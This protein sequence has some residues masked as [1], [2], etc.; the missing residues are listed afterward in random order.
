MTPQRSQYPRTDQSFRPTLSQGKGV[1]LLVCDYNPSKASYSI[2]IPVS[3]LWLPRSFMQCVL[4][5]SFRVRFD[6][7]RADQNTT[8]TAD[9]GAPDWVKKGPRKAGQNS[10]LAAAVSDDGHYL[11]VGGGDKR[12]HVWDI[13]SHEYIQVPETIQLPVPELGGL[14]MAVDS[15]LL[16]MLRV[17]AA[18]RSASKQA[19]VYGRERALYGAA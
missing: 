1:P 18:M 5:W 13:R 4:I 9:G 11:A 2:C 8:D 15:M 6:I 16:R 14:L 7:E 3:D 17:F 12:V 19:G 10:L